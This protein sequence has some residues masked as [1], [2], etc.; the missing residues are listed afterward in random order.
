MEPDLTTTVR[1]CHYAREDLSTIRQT[2]L[3]VHAEV[4]APDMTEFR[5]RFPWFVGHWGNNPGFSCT[6]AYDGDEP[7][8]FAYGAPAAPGANGGESSSTPH[9]NIRE[10]SRSRN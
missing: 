8:G 2:L 7:A 1:V 9:R 10:P 3:D 6:I 5:S 4:H